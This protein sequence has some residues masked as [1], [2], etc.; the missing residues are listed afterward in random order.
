MK[1]SHQKEKPLM[2]ITVR[3]A[4]ISDMRSKYIK[5]IISLTA[6]LFLVPGC[7]KVSTMYYDA[8][9]A[10][11]EN[12]QFPEAEENLRI[13][14]D[15][16]A[17]TKE[18]YRLYGIACL[19]NGKY[20]E[21]VDAF[22]DALHTNNGSVREIDYDI[23]YYLGL[24]YEK[25]EQYADA[26]DVYSAIIAVRPGETESYYRRA[27]CNLHLGK[28]SEAD[29]DFLV[30]TGKNPSDIDKYLQI[31]FAIGDAG[32]KTEAESYL[33][34]LLGSDRKISDFDIGRI[35]YYLGDYSN[36]RVYLEKAKDFSNADTYLMLGKTYEAIG[37]L[38][39]AGSLYSEYLNAKGNNAAVYNQLGVCRTSAGDYE[40]ALTAFSLGLNLGD[41][42]WTGSLMFNEAVTYEYLLDFD[43]AY[44]KMTEYLKKYPKDEAAQH[45]LIFLETRRSGETETP[46]AQ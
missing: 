23:N 40:G 30:V 45:E 24:A 11:L 46:Q 9:L 18:C 14:L 8:G 13:S 44:D 33:K 2:K 16:E 1:K 22:I 35:Y 42:E 28:L 25:L 31:F 6:A 41:S 19:S 12:K 27:V 34:A 37:D 3:Y 21:A 5:G 29:T 7:G 17:K 15:S 38:N 43:T 26:A 39:Y 4:K 36:A 20:T 10:Y 32:Y